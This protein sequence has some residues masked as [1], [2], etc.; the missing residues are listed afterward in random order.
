MSRPRGRPPQIDRNS[1]VEAGIDVGLEKLTLKRV[2]AKLGVHPSSIAYHLAGRRE[3]EEAVASAV[4][5]IKMGDKWAPPEGGSWQDWIRA[6]ANELRRILLSHTTLVS[7]FRIA[8]GPGTASLEQFDT[9]L[10][11]LRNAGFS[12]KQVAH[13]AT[14][15]AQVVFMS[16]RDELMTAISGVHPQ[17]EE[18]ARKLQ[19]MPE[20]S[21]LNVRRLLDAGGHGTGDDQFRFD[22]ECAIA[23]LERQVTSG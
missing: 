23:G 8:P 5:E 15:V 16:V 11:S 2:A 19:E 22:I 18:I 13:A 21:L 20:D 14:F 10:G 1:I 9:F 17:D 3:L 6:F 12:S 4:F 7:Y